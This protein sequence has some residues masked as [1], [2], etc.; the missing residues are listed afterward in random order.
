RRYFRLINRSGVLREEINWDAL[1][2]YSPYETF[3][4]IFR[5]ENVQ[6]QSYF[7]SMTHGLESR[8]PFLD[9]ALMELT[10][11]IPSNIKFKDGTMKHVLKTAMGPVLPA[12]I[13]SRR[14]KMGFPV[15]LHEWLSKPGVV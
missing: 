3:Q 10:A 2:P 9:H 1:G 12:S 15:P 7:V 4:G 8:V 13:A 14:D 5:G 11:T 6:R